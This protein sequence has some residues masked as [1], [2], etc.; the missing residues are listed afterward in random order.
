MAGLWKEQS[1]LHDLDCS[2]QYL[3]SGHIRYTLWL[4]ESINC[5]TVNSKKVKR[6]ICGI[7][8]QNANVLMSWETWYSTACK[9]TNTLV[10][11]DC[12]VHHLASKLRFR[13]T[14]KVGPNINAPLL[15][16]TC[17]NNEGNF[18]FITSH[19]GHNYH[20]THTSHEL[21]SCNVCFSK[22]LMSDGIDDDATQSSQRLFF[23]FFQDFF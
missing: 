19:E 14:I 8:S 13:P 17:K 4:I 18:K 9:I 7:K 3:D 11:V 12:Y 2:S 15:S 23:F 10:F 20:L 22:G 1:S 16:C 5:F 21:L 6:L